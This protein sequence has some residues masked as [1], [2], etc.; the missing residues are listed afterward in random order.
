GMITATRCWRRRGSRVG[1]L[2]MGEVV[3]CE[4]ISG[5]RNRPPRRRVRAGFASTGAASARGVWLGPGEASRVGSAASRPGLGR[6]SAGGSVMA[7][8]GLCLAVAS[9]GVAPSGASFPGA[10]FAV[11]LFAADFFAAPF[12]AV[13]PSGDPGLAALLRA[14]ASGSADFFATAFFAVAFF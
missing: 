1:T 10:F 9:R 12:L 5:R 7:V 3:G 13:G 6:C 2:G 8:P 4:T 14:R 11:V